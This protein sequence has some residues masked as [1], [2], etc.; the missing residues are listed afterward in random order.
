MA[1]VKR[2][3]KLLISLALHVWDLLADALLRLLGR[4]HPARCVVLYYHAVP[5]IHRERFARQMDLLLRLARP[6]AS[7]HSAPLG[8]GAHYAAVTFDDGFASVLENAAPELRQR[9]IPWTMFVPSA[10]LGQ[11]PGWLR[12]A[13]SAARADRVMTANELRS[14][15][16]DPLVTIGSH[17]TVHANLLEVGLPQ[18]A[19]ELANSKADLEKLLG[20]PVTEFSYPFGARSAALDEQARQ[21]GYRRL[22]STDPAWAL[23]TPAE[24]VTGRAGVDP[25]ISLL[26]FRLKLLG[27][28]RWQAKH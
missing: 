22:F 23:Q 15:A 1:L 3:V 10:C 13:H 16:E 27:A 9:Q 18:A 19:A 21:A 2:S 11:R 4:P 25:D 20:R 24:T 26:E 5:A 7:A 12:N 28:Y 8:P 6:V 17:T 14:L